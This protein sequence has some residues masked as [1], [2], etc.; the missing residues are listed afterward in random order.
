MSSADPDRVSQE[1]MSEVTE[2]PA[3]P[4]AGT[5]LLDEIMA[6]MPETVSRDQVEVLVAN[7]LEQCAEGMVQYDTSLHNSLERGVQKLDEALSQQLA[8]ILH[9]PKLQ[10]LEG[11]WRGLQYLVSNSETCASLKL[12]VL[13]VTK[14]ELIRDFSHAVDFDQS[15]AFKLVYTEEFGQAGG[16]PYAALLG[17]FEF[18]NHPQD[19]G[20]LRS[21]S[22]VAAAAFAPF[23]AAASPK[24]FGHD[25]YT[26]LNRSRTLADT[27]QGDD[28]IAWRSFR[29]DP[30]SRFVALTL[31]RV[32]ARLPYGRATLPIAEFDF[33]EFER[34][35]RGEHV[36]TD[37]EKYC[38][39]NCCFAF[40]AR[41]T[42]AFAKHNWCTQI[43]GFDSGGRV[44][45]LPSHL[46]TTEDGDRQQKCPTEVLIP[47][48]RDAE[49]SNLGFLPLV[50][51]KHTDH[52]TFLTSSTVFEPTR[53]PTDPA[54]TANDK[55]GAQLPYVMSTSRIAHFL[56]A[57]GLK[58]LGRQMEAFEVE[59]YFTDWVSQF[60]YDD[61]A[62]KAD[63]KAKYP[64]RQAAIQVLEDEANPGVYNVRAQ[65]RPWLHVKELN[66][67]LELV[68]KLPKPE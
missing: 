26:D 59:Q 29:K 5:G 37:H 62:P 52:A 12:K 38:W 30:D 34:N 49:L 8:E 19:I 21:M 53:Y 46:V 18:E 54:R 47:A 56:K 43:V 60:V 13:D 14:T 27:F 65:L 66:A 4:A 39:M 10:R 36:E 31:P 45:N 25:S 1:E 51:W 64:L 32:L 11:T 68:A 22:K 48:R 17:D 63:M 42:D 41:L 16:A 57:M 24:M 2:V 15:A 61:P 44:E 40:G 6:T 35:E 9:H 58:L 33:E 50:N 3:A 67:S 28:Y 23:I 55:L 7:L 20:F